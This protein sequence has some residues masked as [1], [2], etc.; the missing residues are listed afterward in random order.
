MRTL[1]T[2][3]GTCIKGVAFKRGDYDNTSIINAFY[4]EYPYVVVSDSCLYSFALNE[5]F[6]GFNDDI[7]FDSSITLLG[8]MRM[9]QQTTTEMNNPIALL[10]KDSIQGYWVSLY[11]YPELE[12]TH[13]FRLQFE[14]ELFEVTDDGLYISGFDNNEY[15][16]YHYST[17]ANDLLAVYPLAENASNAKE[18]LKVE[19]SLYV[20]SSPGDTS[21]ILTAINGNTT[22]S[23]QTLINANAGARATNN[24]FKNS[25]Y[26]TF[27]PM[28][29]NSPSHLDQQILLL[30][31]VDKQMDTIIIDTELDY[32]KQPMEGSRGWGYYSLNW[33]GAKWNDAQPDSIYLAQYDN[34]VKVHGD[35]FPNYINATYGCWVGSNKEE[36][37][38]IKFEF[39]PNPTSTEVTI[40]LSGLTKGRK[41]Q[42]D[43]IDNAN[44]VIHT[45]KLEAYQKIALPLENL[46]KGVYLLKLNTGQNMITKKLVIN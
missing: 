22:I 2:I 15:K 37:E 21:T 40:N 1:T 39:Y 3:P 27:Q 12:E 44:K 46:S 28:F 32:F 43:I 8:I 25:S 24:E 35:A 45:T 18:F 19:D 14:P 13:G 30:N 20:L 26:F 17:S 36:L 6:S 34:I 5:Q 7:T 16:L 10:I 4:D 41:Y 31:P 9:A 38:T 23:S 11:S 33:V 42:L 29:D